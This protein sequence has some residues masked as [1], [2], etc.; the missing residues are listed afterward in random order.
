MAA[1]NSRHNKMAVKGSVEST[2]KRDKVNTPKEGTGRLIHDKSVTTI[3]KKKEEWIMV[4]NVGK[5]SNRENKTSREEEKEVQEPL[6]GKILGVKGRLKSQE[7][8]RW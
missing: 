2:S 5:R 7:A 4:S 1:D 8:Q 3:G 6:R